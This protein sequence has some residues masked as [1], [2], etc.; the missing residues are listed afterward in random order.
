MQY[1]FSCRPSYF[2]LSVTTTSLGAH[3]VV[4]VIMCSFGKKGLKSVYTTGK[5]DENLLHKNISDLFDSLRSC[6]ENEIHDFIAVDSIMA[7]LN[8]YRFLEEIRTRSGK[9]VW[10]KK[11]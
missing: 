7:A 2:D 8:I 1:L 4:E 11:N 6:S 9:L 10:F 5:F 3:I